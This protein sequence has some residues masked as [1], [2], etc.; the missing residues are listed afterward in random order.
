MMS[1][2]D[3]PAK[4]TAPESSPATENKETVATAPPDPA[5]PPESEPTQPAESGHDAP[6]PA[7]AASQ[8]APVTPADPSPDS[9]SVSETT[10]AASEAAA[11]EEPKRRVRL[12]PTI[13]TAPANAVASVEPSPSEPT[14]TTD[15]PAPAATPEAEPAQPE[16][17]AAPEVPAATAMAPQ[18]TLETSSSP[19]AAHGSVEIPHAKQALDSDTEAEIEAAMSSG[20]LDAALAGAM[21]AAAQDTDTEAPTSEDELDK[22]DKLTGKIQ[23]IHGDDVFLDVGFRSPGVVPIRQFTAGR[24]PLVGQLMEVLVERYNADDG[25]ILLNLPRGV[26]RSSGDWETVAVGQTVDAMVTGTNKGGLEVSV[27]SLRGFMPASQVDVG[28]V[29]DLNVYVGQKL[30]AQVTEVNPKKR[31]LVVSRR[32]ILQAER[33]ER[34]AEL[35][36][37]LAVGQTSPGKVKTLKDYG[38]F[39]DI[40]GVDGFLHIG[41]ISWTRIGHPSEV[42]A[43]GQEIDVK[44]LKLDPDSKKISLGMKQLVVN[45]WMAASVNYPVD[46]S[47]TGKVTRIADFGAFVQLEPGVEGLVHISEID[48]TRV[49]RVADVLRDGQE[50]TAKVL[51]VDPDRKRISLSIKALIAKP[52]REKRE[53]RPVEAYERTHKGPLKGGTSG[54]T[55]SPGG[56]LFGNPNDFE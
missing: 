6:G 24:K 20:E 32:I 10:P 47:V 8:T 52:E 23:S 39:V 9:E 3:A 11:P 49:R 41:E 50:V 22:G 17:S 44:I 2:E 26:R 31:K 7:D 45:P 12:N 21:P 14:S 53:Q 35:W 55:P 4:D 43:E 33:K 42:L 36:Q 15:S 56:G 51:E 34:E 28:F 29:S 40:G 38:A 25:L 16:A 27:G 37:T 19:A 30:P 18:P 54:D 5:T 1:P 13:G 46:S 48:H